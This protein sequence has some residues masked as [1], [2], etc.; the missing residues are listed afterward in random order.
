[1]TDLS[2][3]LSSLLRADL[4]TAMKNARTLIIGAVMGLLMIVSTRSERDPS[5]MLTN[6]A[7]TRTRWVSRPP[8]R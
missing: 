1:M 2:L 6:S 4:T 5:K 3:T 7:G 8:S